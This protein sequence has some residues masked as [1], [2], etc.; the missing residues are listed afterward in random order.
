MNL[1]HIFE[2]VNELKEKYFNYKVLN[3]IE[4]YIYLQTLFL[5]LW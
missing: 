4:S 3:Y 2:T 5:F 1:K